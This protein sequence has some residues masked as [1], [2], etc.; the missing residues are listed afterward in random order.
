ML[1]SPGSVIVEFAVRL[2]EVPSSAG[3]TSDTAYLQA[4]IKTEIEYVLNEGISEGGKDDLMVAEGSVI[5]ADGNTTVLFTPTP[6]QVL[7]LISG[8][9][10]KLQ[11]SLYEVQDIVFSSKTTGEVVGKVLF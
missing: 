11:T 2:H 8:I 1:C 3:S 10:H 7:D 4:I 6:I 9:R 5:V